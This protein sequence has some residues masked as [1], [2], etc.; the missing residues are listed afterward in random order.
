[1]NT[2]SKYGIP[3]IA[4]L[5]RQIFYIGLLVGILG[6]AA[7]LI[8]LFLQIDLRE[9]L[10]PCSL[11][12]MTGFYCPGCG[13]TRACYALAQGHILESI[14]AHPLV[15]YLAVGY[16][17]YMLS[18]VL[19]LLTRGKIRACYFCPYYWYVGIGILLIQFA[20][21]N[22]ALLAGYTWL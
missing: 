5:S 18:H 8:L 15:L 10:P 17:I 19:N 20:V 21:K 7:V 11:H 6:L 9:I 1:M 16:L 2:E 22:I 12:S 4:R 13:G 14:V 3:N